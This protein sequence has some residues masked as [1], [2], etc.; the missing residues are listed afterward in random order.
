M[1]PEDLIGLVLDVDFPDQDGHEQFGSRP[2][3]IVG[4]PPLIAQGRFPGLIVVPFTSQ[5]N[6]FDGL[7]EE[8][9]PMILAG[10]GGL[11]RDSIALLDQVR[12]IDARR[13]LGQLSKLDQ[14]DIDCIRRNLARIFNFIVEPAQPPLPPQ[15]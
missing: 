14:L 3:V 7:S 1:N 10:S 5:V 11:T 15:P 6:D 4:V 12:Y 13:I 8:L 2:A 9:Y